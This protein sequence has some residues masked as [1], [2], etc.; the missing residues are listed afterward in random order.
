MDE[1][2]PFKFILYFHNGHV[3]NVVFSVI[4]PLVQK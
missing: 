3:N 1:L 4:L 2:G